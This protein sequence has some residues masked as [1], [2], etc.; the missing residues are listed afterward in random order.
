MGQIF[1]QNQTLK[2]CSGHRRI[3]P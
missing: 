1:A 2:S 3:P